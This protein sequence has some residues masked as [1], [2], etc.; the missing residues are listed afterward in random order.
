MVDEEI[1]KRKPDDFLKID[2]LSPW[3]HSKNIENPSVAKFVR[4]VL[5]PKLRRDGSLKPLVVWVRNGRNYVID[6]HHRLIA[7][8]EHG[9]KEPIPVIVV[10]P[11]EVVV[12]EWTPNCGFPHP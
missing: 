3:E 8:R 2:Q 9:H 4:N 1:R 10:R 11:E 7:Y 6:G 5:I 12:T